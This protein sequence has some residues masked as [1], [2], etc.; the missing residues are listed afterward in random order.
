[1]FRATL[2][3]PFS[4]IENGLMRESLSAH[5]FNVT[6][7]LSV[8]ASSTTNNSQSENVCAS[9]D[10]IARFSVAAPLWTGITTE[11]NGQLFRF[12]N[13]E[14]DKIIISVQRLPFNVRTNPDVILT[15]SGLPLL[16]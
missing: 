15:L 9:T 4:L 1:M 2:G 13:C 7:Q 3:P 8:E 12:G 16:Q 6:P 10:S 5:A 11:I 14:V